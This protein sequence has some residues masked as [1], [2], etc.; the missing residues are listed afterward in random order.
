[1]VPFPN[2]GT[3]R[4][5]ATREMCELFILITNLQLLP[6]VELGYELVLTRR[7]RMKDANHVCEQGPPHPKF[8]LVHEINNEHL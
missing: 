1:M 7:S 3:I 2:V 4:N 6:L 5:L 8:K